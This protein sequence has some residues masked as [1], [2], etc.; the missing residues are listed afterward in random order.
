[1]DNPEK[2]TGLFNEKDHITDDEKQELKNIFDSSQRKGSLLF[3]TVISFET[4][5]LEVNGIMDDDGYV[6][7]DILRDYT[8]TAVPSSLVVMTISTS[9]SPFTD[10]SGLAASNFLAVQ[11][12]TDTTTMFSGSMPFFSA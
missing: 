3:Q 9:A 10:I 12:I 5:F 7:E 6:H 4:E 1:M 11:G 2:S 8:R